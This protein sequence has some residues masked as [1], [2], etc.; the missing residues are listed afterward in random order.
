MKTRPLVFLVM[1]LPVASAAYAQRVEI[2]GNF[3]YSASEGIASTQPPLIGQRYD[4]LE[5]K[6]GQS[7]NFT[8]GVFLNE[9][10]QVEF[11]W[12][13][14][15]SQLQAE[16]P[17]GV[18]PV[19]ELH[20]DS[21]MGNFVYNFGARESRMT[22]YLFGGIGATSFAFGQNLLAGGTRSIDN[23][24]RFATNVGGGAKFY[25]NPKVGLKVGVRWTPTY[26]KSD[27]AGVWCDPFYG[28]WQ[29]VNND[30]ANQFET[31]FGVTIRFE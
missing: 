20:V 15:K 12:G 21:Y 24:T 14:Q 17:G 2:S 1:M 22:P 23:E 18:L 16:G 13:R 28:C 9:Q 7:A 8:F 19:S 26:I 10:T 3:G 31:S 5:V 25:F 6:S 30:Y 27:P 11:L 29:T 4:S